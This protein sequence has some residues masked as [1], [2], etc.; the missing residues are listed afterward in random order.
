MDNLNPLKSF[1]SDLITPIVQKAVKDAVPAKENSSLPRFI[2]VSQI[3]EEYGISVSTIYL[4]FNTGELTKHKQGG[5]TFVDREELEK[6]I[7][8]R[9]LCDTVAPKKKSY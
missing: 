8:A 2:P 1:L 4:R 6:S 5:L 7:K 3:P 9:K